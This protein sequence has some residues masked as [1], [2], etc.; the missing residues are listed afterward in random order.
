MFIF[1]TV[2]KNTIQKIKIKYPNDIYSFMFYN[3]L[4]DI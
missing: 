2:V 1:K 3:M 4:S